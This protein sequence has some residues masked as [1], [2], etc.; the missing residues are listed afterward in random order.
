MKEI[1][2]N[3]KQRGRNLVKISGIVLLALVML[4]SIAGAE[5][6]ANITFVTN[7]SSFSPIITVTGNPAIQWTFGD[8][9]TSNSKSP[10]VN[11]GSAGIRENTL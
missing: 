8:G 7:G 2:S 10:T 1:K 5:P 4:V 3:K 6:S 11:F 9:S